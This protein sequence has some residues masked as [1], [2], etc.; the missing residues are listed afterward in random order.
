MIQYRRFRIRIMRN[1]WTSSLN[2]KHPKFNSFSYWVLRS[3][4]IPPLHRY[5]D[6]IWIL[7]GNF[8]SKRWSI[9]I[10]WWM[11]KQNSNNYRQNSAI[12]S[13]MSKNKL[14]YL[15]K[16]KKKARVTLSQQTPSRTSP[17]KRVMEF[18]GHKE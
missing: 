4:V 17:S 10:M 16:N 11:K 14:K 5:V 8:T 1:C 9:S 18:L 15:L 2:T 3:T 13:R 12:P 7:W 6:S